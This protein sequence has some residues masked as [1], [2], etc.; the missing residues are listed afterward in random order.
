MAQQLCALADLLDDM[1]S[2]TNIYT[3]DSSNCPKLQAQGIRF[4]P[5]WAPCI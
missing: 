1:G 4:G 5:L 2:S 3:E